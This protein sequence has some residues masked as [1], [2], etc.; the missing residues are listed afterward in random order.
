MKRFLKSNKW[1]LYTVFEV[2]LLIVSVFYR[3]DFGVI[4]AISVWAAIMVKLASKLYNNIEILAFFISFFVFL[5]GG[6][7]AITYLGYTDYGVI[8][9]QSIENH[10]N[11]VLL[12]SMICIMLGYYFVKNLHKENYIYRLID[13]KQKQISRSYNSLRQVSKCVFYIALACSTLMLLEKILFFRTSGDYYATYSEYKSSMPYIIKTI[14]NFMPLSL[15]IFLGTRPRKKEAMFPICVYLIYLAG[16]LLTGRRIFIVTGLMMIA[17]YMIIND[18][19]T[20]DK[21]ITKRLLMGV[22]VLVPLFVVFL[23][24]YGELR[25]NK[26]NHDFNIFNLFS[27]FIGSQG[28]TI[29]VIKYGKEDAVELGTDKFYSFYNTLRFLRTS[30]LT[31][32]FMS[33]YNFTYGEYTIEN[34]VNGNSFANSITYLN[35]PYTFLKGGGYGSCYIA[36]LFHDF[37]YMGVIFGNLFI[38]VLFGEM[39]RFRNHGVFTMALSFLFLDSM[40]KVPR[41]NFDYPIAELSIVFNWIYMFMVFIIARYLKTSKRISVKIRI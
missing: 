12:I 32:W 17:I 16:S 11:F 39:S 23:T 4:L 1:I 30:P 28:F 33:D 29:N 35:S 24:V 18:H 25:V 34:A 13:V 22:Y 40:L 19:E 5:I 3:A 2:I 8:F 20:D 36:E 14:D 9:P 26:S 21:W 27:K 15:Y 41:Y 10:T 6:Q 31:R 38:G 37:G 7:V